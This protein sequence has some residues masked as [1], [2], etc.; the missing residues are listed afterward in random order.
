[1]HGQLQTVVGSQQGLGFGFGNGKAC[2]PGGDTAP[3]AGGGIL[4]D[5]FDLFHAGGGKA[6]IAV[7]CTTLR[8]QI[9]C[10]AFAGEGNASDPEKDGG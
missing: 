4:H 2:L 3:L 10:P 1:M 8:L 5:A 9:R 6:G 7:E